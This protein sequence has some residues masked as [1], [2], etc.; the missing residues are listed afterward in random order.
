MSR[1]H[2]QLRVFHAANEVV[3][4]VYR[5]QLQLFEGRRVRTRSQIRRAAVSVACNIVE[6]DARESGRDYVIF[7]HIALGSSCELDG[8]LSLVRRL[9]MASG[10][11][12]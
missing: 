1:S 3:L 4:A 11:D 5:Q 6:R 10:P 12:W 9:E 7:L 8:L 2:E